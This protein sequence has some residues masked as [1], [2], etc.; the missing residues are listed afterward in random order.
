MP[1]AKREPVVLTDM[2]VRALRSD[3]G[4]EY[5]QGDLVV[6]GFGVRV[7]PA[8]RP[9][10]II[11]K[12]LPGDAKPTRVTIGRISDISLADAREKARTASAAVRLG[13]DVNAEK[14]REVAAQKVERD[15]VRRIEVETG[16]A[17]G[18]FGETAERYIRA[19]CGA[20][21][22]G[23]EI[24]ATIRRSLLPAW[25]ARSLDELRRRDL[26]TVL[27]PVVAAKK[28]QAAHKLREIAIRLINWAV[29]RGDLEVNYLATSSRGRRR[30]GILR[31]TRRDRVLTDGEVKALWTACDGA[32]EPFAGLIR[33][34]LLLGQRREDVA[35]MEWPELDLDRGL[36]VIR[37]ARYK[38]R[39]EH[40]VPLPAPAV[41]LLREM[42]RVCD[43]FVFS[44]KP[45]THF[46]GF[47]KAKARIDNESGLRA[48]TIHDLRRTM[49]TGLAG[50]G[51]APDIAERVVGHVIGGVRG[52][53][54]RH[55]YLD[56]KRAALERWATH[57]AGLVDPQPGR[58]VRIQRAQ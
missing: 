8:G 21:A 7:R 41:A 39:V 36:W 58:V 10:Y 47:S 9:V 53:Y 54:D 45:G 24:E 17:P 56:E 32:G 38:T 3:P 34:L 15:R 46:S 1:K 13:V 25:G 50:L 48:W 37:A 2:K 6:P 30:A 33:M 20:L 14:R 5:V 12:R 40:A 52:V 31:R 49:R 55:A 43:R 11:T 51:V 19:E 42:P 4:R 44:T 23:A 28:V 26:T 18:T 16:Y 27:D 57:L 22:R 35:G 29:D